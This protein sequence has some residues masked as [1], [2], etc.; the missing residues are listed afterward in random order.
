MRKKI[1]I[2]FIKKM[3]SIN[4]SQICKEAYINRENVYAG[5]VAEDKLSYVTGELIDRTIQAIQDYY[6]DLKEYDENKSFINLER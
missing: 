1:M 5:N 4:T 6:K 2:Q 3:N